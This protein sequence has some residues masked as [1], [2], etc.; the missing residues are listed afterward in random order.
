MPIAFDKE[1]A[2]GIEAYDDVLGRWWR[3]QSSNAAH[4]FAYRH[5]ADYVAASFQGSPWVIVDYACGSGNLLC[6]LASRFPHSRLI[7]L[8]GSSYLLAL[9]QRRLARLGEDAP[10]RVFFVRMVLPNFDLRLKANLVMFTFPNMVPGSVENPHAQVESRLASEDLRAARAIVEGT[11]QEAQ[12]SAYWGLLRSRLISLNLRR[13]LNR[14][15]HCVRV[16]YASVRRDQMTQAELMRAAF[17]EG[18]SDGEAAGRS[19]TPWFRVSASAYF[20]SGVIEDVHCQTEDTCDKRWRLPD[21]R[22][23]RSLIGDCLEIARGDLMRKSPG[24]AILA[25]ALVLLI[26]LSRISSCGQQHPSPSRSFALRKNPIESM[27]STSTSVGRKEGTAAVILMDTS[28][29]MRDSVNDSDGL[30]KPKI[31]IARRA[32]VDAVRRFSDSAPK[33]PERPLLVGVYEFSTRE[34]LPSCRRVIDLAAPDLAATA[35][36]VGK[37]QPEGGTP[38]GDAMIAAKRD[39]DATGL[40]HRHILVVTD[41]KNNVGYS[42]GNVA[43]AMARQ[44]EG[45]RA[46][47]YFIAFD[48]GE[49]VF[50][51][52]KEAGGLVLG[53]SNAT[54]LN[55]ALDFILTG[56]ILVEQPLSPK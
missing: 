24:K 30:R 35:R 51:E 46:S 9:A 4:S 43:S 14:G 48:I 12:D 32:V 19:R 50:N 16:E 27:L 13:L 55:Q 6:R 38:I 10:A 23:S 25:M 3:R 44:A 28:G 54:D 45:D 36:A 26:L 15:G 7:A 33:N 21:H 5:I 52:V 20:R 56:K 31:V 42:P 17:E 40:T 49:S 41:G 37:M 18:T 22:A 1:L 11:D 47:I 53:A 2:R 39:L 8:D 29:S 34:H